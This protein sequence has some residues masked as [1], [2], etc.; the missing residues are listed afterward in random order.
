MPGWVYS[1]AVGERMSAMDELSRPQEI[2]DRLVPVSPAVRDVLLSLV[3]GV[4]E[5]GV[6]ILDEDTSLDPRL[7]ADLAAV[8]T[9]GGSPAELAERL[10]DQCRRHRHELNADAIECYRAAFYLG[11]DWES[12]LDNPL[13]AR[14]NSNKARRPFDKWVHYFDIYARTLA[15]YVGTDVRVLEIGVFHG[16]GL[17]QLRYLLGERAVLVGADVDPAAR[18][19]CLGRFEVA[20]GDQSDPQFLDSV[21]AQYGPFDV[22]IDDGGHTMHQQIT[23]VERLFP[24][25]N[26]GGVYLV[27]DTHTSYW[28]A[29]QDAEETFLEWVKRRVDDLHAYHFSDAAQL[30]VWTTHL[31]GLHVYDSVVVLDKARRYPPFCEVT[32]AGSFVLADRIS[33]SSLLAYR[34]ALGTAL[35]Q[36]SAAELAAERVD[37]Q[38]QV[39]QHEL[40][41]VK[42]SA[43]WRA[44]APLRRLKSRWSRRGS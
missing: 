42:T 20:I 26:D 33:E 16:G 30:P 12:Q 13:F 38:L 2:V 21:V 9:A 19:A 4:P 10:G 34:A 40:E 24:T 14:F 18:D 1:L 11:D 32:G 3:Q 27:E 36:R 37:E 7:R 44:T 29:F 5:R 15:P 35:R 6:E 41:A 31:N 25:L 22:I 8:L 43:S 17:D 39:S 28:G 23:A